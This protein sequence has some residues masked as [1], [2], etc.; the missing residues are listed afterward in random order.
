MCHAPCP[1]LSVEQVLA[2]NY[3]VLP[4]PHPHTPPTVNLAKYEVRDLLY[5]LSIIF[6]YTQKDL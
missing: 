4:S 3:V 6:I 1:L 2:I 5:T